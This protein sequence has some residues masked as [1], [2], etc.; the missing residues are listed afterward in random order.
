[1]GLR[2]GFSLQDKSGVNLAAPSLHK[3]FPSDVNATWWKSHMTNNIPPQ[4]QRR[5]N[6]GELTNSRKCQRE[7]PMPLFPPTLKSWDLI[8]VQ[9]ADRNPG[10]FGV[11]VCTAPAHSRI[12]FYLTRTRRRKGPGVPTPQGTKEKVNLCRAQNNSETMPHPQGST[13]Y[14]PDPFL[15]SKGRC[16]VWEEAMLSSWRSSIRGPGTLRFYYQ[17]LGGV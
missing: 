11:C 8:I 16:V 6:A 5:G 4:M 7:C 9:D 2:P 14:L 10:L 13:N 15:G 3:P 1:M 12:F 17:P